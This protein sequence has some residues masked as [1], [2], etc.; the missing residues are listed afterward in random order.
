MWR[1]L[2]NAWKLGT[3]YDLNTLHLYSLSTKL[4][5][6]LISPIL[7]SLGYQL[8]LKPDEDVAKPNGCV[9]ANGFLLPPS[10]LLTSA[11]VAL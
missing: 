11:L 2:Y 7:R 4:A 6:P 5:F 10:I 9:L 8:P 1:L 3:I